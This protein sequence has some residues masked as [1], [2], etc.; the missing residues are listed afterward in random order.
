[1]EGGVDPIAPNERKDIVKM[2]LKEDLEQFLLF[3][4]KHPELKTLKG[5]E[6]YQRLRELEAL[7][8]LP[9]K[10]KKEHEASPPPKSQDEPAQ[11]KDE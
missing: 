6:L 8:E 11:K 7:G 5:E 10:E 2:S 1:M 3:C 4:E 9:S